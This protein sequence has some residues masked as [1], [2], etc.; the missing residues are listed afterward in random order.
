MKKY[1]HILLATDF[2]KLSE[3]AAVRAI[4]L[5]K[6]YDAQLTIFHGV[7]H[8][9]ED[10]PV[11][12][13]PPENVDPK[14]FLM[15][16]AQEKLS[17]FAKRFKCENANQLVALSTSSAKHEILQSAKEQ[18]ADLIVLGSHSEHGLMKVLG[19]TAVGVLHGTDCDVLTVRSE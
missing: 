10:L 14:S 2:S 17:E 3:S 6:Y 16:N 9:P 8:F 12:K 11:D 18:K 4:E 5:S 15:R 1:Q 19:S 13:V 7:E